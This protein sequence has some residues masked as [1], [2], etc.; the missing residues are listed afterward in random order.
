V[1]YSFATLRSTAIAGAF[2]VGVALLLYRSFRSRKGIR[3]KPQ[4]TR[5][6]L[7]QRQRGR[8]GD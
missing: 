2:S 8:E 1:L 6:N 5:Q 3:A 4:F 7:K